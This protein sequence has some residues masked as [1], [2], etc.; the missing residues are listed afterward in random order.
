MPGLGT[1]GDGDRH[2]A[3]CPSR[4]DSDRVRTR[5]L[6]VTGRCDSESCGRARAASRSD[7]SAC[8]SRRSVGGSSRSRLLSLE[9]PILSIGLPAAAGGCDNLQCG[10][11]GGPAQGD[12][13]GL[14]TTVA[15]VAG[16]RSDDPTSDR[17]PG[18]GRP[19]RLGPRADPDDDRGSTTSAGR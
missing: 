8:Q 18:P 6:A 1:R 9:G 19:P 14:T 2:V 12:D 7:E 10:P 16:R 3:E 11:A 13:R 4:R 17:G 5:I 15:I